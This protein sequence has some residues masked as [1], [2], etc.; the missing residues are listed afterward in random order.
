MQALYDFIPLV[1]FFVAYRFGGIYVATGVLLA[2][3]AVQVLVQWLRTRKV[4]P[5]LL[6]SAG[7]AA[8]FGG[9]TLIIHDQ[10]FIMWK[11][12]V[13]YLLFAVALAASQWFTDKPVV[14]R[15]LGAQFT[16]DARTWRIANATWAVFFV[17]LAGVNYA[18][19]R[20][21]SAAAPGS[22]AQKWWESAWVNWKFATFGVVLVFA[23]LQGL[24]LVRHA[25]PVEPEKSTEPPV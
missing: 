12:T 10:L 9:L 13:L 11:P 7:L 19:V 22:E 2:A 14:Q 15:M 20:G 18:F 17:A 21:F 4:S 25:Q 3:T 1:A 8:V 24:W 16:A 23:F 6:I 5:M